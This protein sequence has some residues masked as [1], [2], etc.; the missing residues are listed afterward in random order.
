MLAKRRFY[1]FILCAIYVITGSLIGQTKQTSTRS[2]KAK[3]SSPAELTV[4]DISKLSKA[5]ISQD[6]LEAKILQNGKT[7]DLNADQILELK[8]AGVND[9]LIRVMMDFKAPASQPVATAT[10]TPK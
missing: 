9:E 2:G 7:F 5:G 3:P 6:V 1:P 10:E 8:A 4:N